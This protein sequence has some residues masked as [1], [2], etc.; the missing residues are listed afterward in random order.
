MSDGL[1]AIIGAACRFPGASDLDAFWELLISGTDAITEVDAERW[2]TRFYYHPT[3]GTP[4]KSYTWSAGMLTGVDCFEP[5]FFG[6]SP[7]EA[8]QMDPQQRLLLELIWHAAEDAGI[9]STRLAGSD[10][11]VY[12]GASSTDYRDLRLGDPASGDSYFMTGGTLSILANRISYVF[13]LRGPSLTVDTACSSSLV[14]LHHACEAIR[15]GRVGSAIVGGINLLLSPYP[16]LGFCRA[17]MLSRKG[18]C[19]AFDARADGYVRGE[20]GGVIILK[21]LAQALADGDRIRAVIR[22]TGVNSDG[23]TIGLS[24]PSEAAQAA[25]IR[26]V[27]ARADVAPDD[28]AFFEMH[29]TGTPAGDPIEAAAVG[30]SL[31]Q[32]RSVPLPIGS[33]KTNIGHLEP[34]SGM[35]GLIKAALALEHGIVPP[36]LYGATPNP[37]IAFDDLNL[38]LIATPETIAAGACAGV[39]SFGFGG[40]NGHAVLAAPPPR[41]E[42]TPPVAE[43]AALQSPPLVISARTEASLREL[44]QGWHNALAAAPTDRAAAL[45]RAAARRRDQHPQRLVAWGGSHADTVAALADYIAGADNPD[46]ITG[47]ALRDDKLAFVFAGNGAQWAGMGRHTYR[48]NPVFRD[49][50]NAA[51]RALNPALGWSVAAAIERGV[52]ATELVRADVAQ[53]LLFAIQ[54]GIVTVLRSLGIEAAGHIGH[55]VG[56]IA[57]AWASGALSLPAAAR[58]VVARSRH[59][60]RTRGNGRMAAL[61]LGGPAAEELLNEL[62]SPLEVGAINATQSV[63]VSGP[64]EAIERLGAEAQRR[65]VAFR[66]LDLEFAFHSA[67]MD[68]TRGG[69]IADLK[70]LTSETPQ[71]ALVS[72]VTGEAVV[73]GELDAEYWWHN[74]RSPVRFTDGMA[75]LLA[76]GCRILVEI[77]PHPVLQSYLHDALRAADA[78]GRVLGSLSRRQGEEDPFPAIAAR[79]HVAGYDIVGAPAFD[80]PVELRGLPLYPWQKERFWFERTVEGTNPINPPFGHPLLGFQQNGPVPF[81]LNHLDPEVLPWLG[82]HAIEGVPVMPAAAVLEM[83]LAAAWLRRP[84]ARALEIV[85]LELRRPLPFEKGRSREVRNVIASEDGDWELTSRPRLSDEPPTLHAVARLMTAGDHQPMPPAAELKPARGEVGAAALY[86]LAKQLGL[87]YGPQFRTVKRIELLDSG[88]AM[89]HLDPSVIDAPLDDYLIHPALLDGALQGLLAL[90]AERETE[91]DGVSFLPWRFGR[92][93]L[94]GPF[95]RPASRARLRVTRVGTRSASA[96]IVLFDAADEPIGELSE[97]WFRRVALT[98]RGGSE[99][100]ALHIDLVPAPLTEAA[101]PTILGQI[102]RV[103]ANAAPR[104]AAPEDGP[105]SGPDE[106]ALLLDALIAAVAWQSIVAIATPDRAFAVEELVQTGV[107]AADAVGIFGSLLRLLEN[108][109]AAT[110]AAGLWTVPA[111]NDLPDIAELWRLLLAE[112]PELVAELAMVAAAAEELPR[113]LASGPRAG[114]AAPPPMVEHLVHGSPVSAAGIELVCQALAEIARE[115]PKAQPL[116][117]LE[118]GADGGATRRILDRLTQSGIAF[119]YRATN[120]EAEQAARLGFIVADAAGA[121]AACWSPRDIDDDIDDARFDIILSVHACA[122]LQLDTDALSRLRDRLVP[123]GLFIAVE[124]APNPLWDLVF[125]QYSGWWRGARN[126]VSAASPLRSGGEWRSELAIGGFDDLGTAIVAAGPWPSAALWGRAPSIAAAAPAQRPSHAISLID[127]GSPG[128]VGFAAELT[129]AGHRV[130]TIDAAAF[131]TAAETDAEAGDTRFAVVLI[132]DTGDDAVAQTARAISLVARVASVAA[133]QHVPLYL[134]TSGA[135]QAP[136]GVAEPAITGAAIWGFGRV[137]FNEMP[138]LSL[139]LIDLLPGLPG[140][141]RAARF[142]QEL[143]A[144]SDETEIVWTAAGRHVLRLR[145]GL[146][147][148]WADAGD[149]LALTSAQQGGLDSLGWQANT[150]RAPGAGEVTIDVHAAGLNFRDMMWAM[151]LLPEE[152]LIDGFA[153]PTFGLECAGIVREVGEGV[154]DLA[155]GDRVAGFAPAALSTEV[156]T[157]AHAVTR[158]PEDMSFAAAATI[159]VTFVTAIYALGTLAR[160]APGELVLVHAAAGGVGLAAIQYAKYRGA[161]VIATA[162]SE[163]KRAFLRLAGADHVLDSRDLSFADAIREISGGAG[164]DVVLNSLSGEA[165][166]QSLSV[167]KP[168]G[169][170]LELGKRDFYLNRRIHLRPLRQNITY[171]AID[172]DQLPV[173]RPDL[174]RALLTEVSEALREGAIRPLAHRTFAFAEIGEAFRLMQASGH[175]GKLVLVPDGNAGVKLRQAAELGLRPDGT[176]LVTGGISGFGFAAAR[177]LAQH[178]ATSLALVGRRGADT[179]E[180]AARIAELHNLGAE[181]RLYA[182]DVSDEASL[183]AVLTQIRRDQPPLRGVVHAASAIAD[184]LASDVDNTDIAGILEAKLGG[185]LALDR[186][187]RDDPIELF[188]LFSSATTLLGAPGQGVYVA[189]NLAVEALARQRRAAGRP[190][191]AVA[192]GPIEDTGYLADRPETRDALA[193]RLGA[194]PMPAAQALAALPALVES[195]LA[196]PA[197]ADTS[198]NEARRFLPILASPVFAELRS[199]TGSSPGD[200]TLI[201]RLSELSSDEAVAL[202]KTAVAEEAANILRLPAS[203]IDPLRPLSEMGMDSLMAVELRLA[204]ESRLRIDLPLMSL[205]EGTSV[206]SIAMRLANAVS[207]SRPHASEIM[208]LAERYEGGADNRL[209]EMADTA[210]RFG[211]LDIKSEAA[212]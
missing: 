207:S 49:A 132:D 39:N 173:Q 115:W 61:A 146:P 152:A 25:L 117:V 122:R 201:E 141:E 85:D 137:L 89:V 77:G 31:G 178:G 17:S 58:V 171:F 103:V 10:T 130:S 210:D 142:A 166:E 158:V 153:G 48:A 116:R 169:R 66:A 157:A 45:L 26:T 187:T 69:L 109:G 145:R 202:L 181:A 86:R 7:R 82:D 9:P 90:I 13:D 191:L 6:I 177:W 134:V 29:G 78:Q 51:D 54:V 148:R 4:A 176:Y 79:C 8:A 120:P 135:Q 99:D 16:F 119:T 100:S 95:G 165:M 19:F 105:E 114:D 50:V 129:R 162:G 150:R 22:G 80:G 155:V 3:L 144:A 88:E 149:A 1:I 102:E 199:D 185:A 184:G 121:S 91:L 73:A 163:V 128:A 186:L 18:R 206:A 125:G 84:D 23:R 124:P 211:P 131:A 204:L 195:G 192:W 200:D 175:I 196:A 32:G 33:V 24:L 40:T 59:Q 167:L 140:A 53:P 156:T 179:P 164:I 81:W 41:P 5:A 93:R 96:E 180:A 123:G 67:A 197:F 108:F 183:A 36:T 43:G 188:L 64:R 28:L 159:P 62:G 189:A 21:P 65:G 68:P 35:A 110:E 139:R 57:A 87:D 111:V 126:D 133:Q 170:F 37:N 198:W 118:I 42:L 182:G 27:Y 143:A 172:V 106:H 147:P 101:S 203:G 11:G 71:T 30:R 47:S 55:S 127:T 168:F 154:S 136:D 56:E 113:L 205:A 44:A 208:G 83:A 2:S 94:V 12:I 74:I 104:R 92:V 190:A 46:V 20:G 212:E 151:G 52:E 194:K 174:A 107:L 112:A 60:E 138:R 209:A 14:A 76:A 75:A 97:C 193:R 98:R 72:T 160:L 63:T 34:A 15:G 70:G 161:I 38:R